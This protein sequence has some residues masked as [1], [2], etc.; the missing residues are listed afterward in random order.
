MNLTD[1]IEFKSFDKIIN[2]LKEFEEKHKWIDYIIAPVIVAIILLTVYAIK[3]VYPFG[4]NTIAYYDMPTQY[5]P[6]YAGAWDFFHGKGSLYFDWYCGTGTSI[7]GST[8][9]YIFFPT[10]ILL[11]LF[12]SRDNIIFFMSLLL[13]VKMM[14]SAF[15]MS[16]YS[17]KAEYSKIW[18]VCSGIL[19]AFSGYVIQYYTNIFFLDFVM[20]FPFVVWSFERLMFKHK[21]GLFILFVILNVISSFRMAMLVVLYLIIKCY[22]VLK[23]IPE[24]DQGR[25][26]RL[27]VMC[28]IIAALVSAFIT[29][30]SVLTVMGTSRVERVQN[31][32]YLKAMRDVYNFFRREKHFIMYGSEISVGL[33][34]L[35]ILQGK[36]KVKKY[37]IRLILIFL[38][39]ISILHEGINLLWHFGT[40]KHFPIRYG[41]MITFECML[42]VGDY[43]KYEEYKSIKVIGKIAK[44][45]GLSMLPFIAYV[46]F[47]FT[48][49]FAD[50]GISDLSGYMSY[51]IY[52]ITLSLAYFVILLM[53]S[54]ESRSIA[55]VSLTIIQAVCGCYGFIAPKISNIDGSRV[56]YFFNALDSKKYFNV[57]KD[58]SK[59]VKAYTNEYEPNYALIIERP[60]I[61][62]WRYGVSADTE[63]ELCDN[64]GYNG[65]E[66]TIYAD[67]GTA[68]TDALL[69]VNYVLASKNPDTEL[70]VEHEKDSKL[71]DCVYTLPFGILLSDDIQ[72]NDNTGSLEYQND[73]FKYITS[74]EDELIRI[75][76]IS[77][78]I[79]KQTKL[80]DDETE[81]I[82]KEFY[83]NAGGSVSDINIKSDIN[84]SISGEKKTSESTD[85]ES[86]SKDS[87]MM[88]KYLIE[89]PINEK[90]TLY[91]D[92]TDNNIGN[93]MITV[94]GE[95]KAFTSYQTE[96]SYQY[97]NVVWNG[98]LSLGSYEDSVV[99]L[100]LYTMNS[101][102]N[103][104]ELGILDHGVLEKGLMSVN[105]GNSV[106]VTCFKNKMKATGTAEKESNLFIPIGYSK[107]WHAR[108]NG[109]KA[110]IVPLINKAFV[111]VKVP[112]GNFYVDFYYMPEGL[113]SGIIIS[114]FGIICLIIIICLSKNT[115]AL[116]FKH[117]ELI[118]KIT[119]IGY[120]TL[121]YAIF[122]MLYIVPIYIKLSL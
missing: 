84:Q 105:D 98:I 49:Q 90:G 100:E 23:G 83:E 22:F 89:I 69:G 51:W 30:P 20:L 55:I 44:L 114:G 7:A 24:K 67:G 32:N 101:D 63:S 92:V 35:L 53:D 27:F 57:E 94:N 66:S 119:I 75:I 110:E 77:D 74:E 25:S 56:K 108:V 21:F 113:V 97:P 72:K 95:R 103:E 28:G 8:G 79:K 36:E 106:D 70:Y 52:F 10:N 93:Y 86:E 37:Y 112:K 42:F 87:N 43:F 33:L 29:V 82:E 45:A 88:Y 15:A 81:K 47:A 68:F 48:K 71:Y 96:Y 73:L 11:L 41:F 91:F 1:Q 85:E 118:D 40:Y 2:K 34:L 80:S 99:E 76:N 26:I 62:G 13:L 64:M 65:L 14:I 18:V 60:S 121:I 9:T 54:R 107:N 3:G 61:A 4:R 104:V 59:R 16:F 102:L 117:I 38:L 19:Y 122:I 58:Y 50:N 6:F 78:Y 46:L 111:A 120:R 17:R 39:S 31:F 12:V 115:S 116:N 109:K 5:V